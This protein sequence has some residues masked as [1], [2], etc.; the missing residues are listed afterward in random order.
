VVDDNHDILDLLEVFLYGKYD[1]STALN[2]LKVSRQ[3]V[4]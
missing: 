1:L 3:P 4:K 2:G